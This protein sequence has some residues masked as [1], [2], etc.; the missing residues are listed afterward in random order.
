MIKIC[1]LELMEAAVLGG[2]WSFALF[3]G[4][5]L[6]LPLDV[7]DD[8][9]WGLEHFGRNVIMSYVIQTNETPRLQLERLS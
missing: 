6:L 2:G 5:P 4:D 9:W 3:G 1:D 7:L 8:L